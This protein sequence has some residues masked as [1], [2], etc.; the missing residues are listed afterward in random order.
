[1]AQYNYEDQIE[2]II[3]LDDPTG[4]LQE[5][6]DQIIDIG[7]SEEEVAQDDE[8]TILT[9]KKKKKKTPVTPAVTK[10]KVKE[11]IKKPAAIDFST[12][13]PPTNTEFNKPT[14]TGF[15]FGIEGQSAE[16][17]KKQANILAAKAKQDAL[18]QAEF[19]A[20]IARK[21][22]RKKNDE[23]L[24]KTTPTK[25]YMS[26]L[27][28]E[29]ATKIKE[30]GKE[31]YVTEGYG[32]GGE[33]GIPETRKIKINS[34]APEKSE[35]IDELKK[36]G[37]L[38]EYNQKQI[39][40][41]AAEKYKKKKIA[42]YVTSQS[43]GFYSD[44]DDKTKKIREDYL[45]K[46]KNFRKLELENKATINGDIKKNLDESAARFN[47]I[48]AELELYGTKPIFKNQEEVNK[49][50]KLVAKYN[51]LRIGTK[52]LYD[53]WEINNK[54]I[55]NSSQKLGTIEQE[56]DLTK[57]NYNWGAGFGT[58]VFQG[59][60]NL[61]AQIAQLAVITSGLSRSTTDSASRYIALSNRESNEMINSYLV[62]EEEITDAITFAKAGFNLVATQLPSWILMYATGGGSKA[63]QMLATELTEAAGKTALETAAKVTTEKVV[64][65]IAVEGFKIASQQNQYLKL[66]N[67]AK[68]KLT[69]P[70]EL[71]AMAL[72]SGAGKYNEQVASN[73]L[74][75]TNFTPLQMLSS[76]ALYGYAEALG[77][78]VTLDILKTG[79]RTLEAAVKNNSKFV[80]GIKEKTMK[81]WF[82]SAFNFVGGKA[83]DFANENI[84]EQFTN[85][86]QNAV[87]KLVLGKNVNLLDNTGTVFKDT[88]ILTSLMLTAPH[89]GGLAI[90]PFL[91][92][93]QTK[94]VEDTSAEM[95]KYIELLKNPALSQQERKVFSNK[96]KE[97]TEKAG[98]VFKNTIKDI[99]GMPK[100]VFRTILKSG[101]ELNSIKE[102]AK[103]IY[104]S[105]SPDKMQAIKVLE[106]EYKQKKYA[107]NSLINRT[108]MISQL[109]GEFSNEDKAK[110]FN[111]TNR[112]Q[113]L[114]QEIKDLKN[115]PNSSAVIAEKALE[116]KQIN[117]DIGNIVA[118]EKVSAFTKK[119]LAAAKSGDIGD[120]IFVFDTTAEAEAKAKELG[121]SLVDDEGNRAEGLEIDGTI[122][123][124][125]QQAAKMFAFNVAGHEVL[126][127]VLRKTIYSTEEIKDKE[128]N[129]IGQKQMGA[130]RGMTMALKTYLNELDPETL[131]DKDLKTRLA[132]YN[133][134]GKSV[135]AEETLTIFAD[136]LRLGELELNE[137]ALTKVGDFIR[138]ALQDLGW[139]NIKFKDGKDVL[140]FLK[141]YNRAIEKGKLG[142]AITKVAKEGATV[143]RGKDG[144]KN[145]KDDYIGDVKRSKTRSESLKEQLEELEDNE[146]DYDPDDFD[147]R[148]KSLKGQIARAIEKEKTEVKSEVKKEASEEDIVKEIINNEKGSISSDKVQ[149]IFEEKGVNGAA[150]II[151]LFKPITNKIVNKRKD[152]PGFDRELLTDEI[153]TG[154]GGILD[155][156]AK[157]KP[158]SGIPLAAW[159]N[160][161]L[162]VRA[163][164][165][166]RR[167]L[168]K[169]FNKDVTEEKGLLAEEASQEVK[170][171]PKYK[172]ALE[173][174]V[175]SPE[176]LE[177]ANKKILSV[178]RTLKSRIDA[179]VS[180]NKTVTPLISEIRDQ[181]GK[182]LDID[183]K[184]MLGGKKDGVLKKELLR[185]KQY[186]LEN[187]TTTWLM[188][189]DG[190]GGIPM[191][192]QKQIDGKWVNF[193]DWVG[194]K[195]D[196][197]KTTT[198]QA[199]R[200]SGAE[201]V[202]RLPNVNNNVS[203]EVF[204]S[205]IIGPDGNPLRGRKES[206]SKAIA[207]EA[208]FDIINNDFENE[209]PI[210]DAFKTNQERLGVELI[211]NVAT[212][213]SRQIERGN[214]KFSLTP[215]KFRQVASD[216]FHVASDYGIES[217]EVN[218][219]INKLPIDE[220][221]KVKEYVFGDYID[222]VA[223]LQNI[224]AGVRGTA[225]ENIILKE[226]KKLKLNGVKVINTKAKGFDSTGSGD[227]NIQLDSDIL[228]I[229]VKLNKLAQMGSFSMEFD[230]KNNTFNPSQK[231]D[232][233]E[234]LYKKLQDKL[235]SFEAYANAAENLGI[236]TSKW[237]YKITKE[238]HAILKK[239]GLQKNLTVSIDTNQKV[240]E[241][242]YNNKDVNY[243]NIG[244]NGLFSLGKD[245]LNL[246]VPQLNSKVKLTAR[247]V[248]GGD[249][250]RIRV[251]PTLIDFNQ[252]SKYNIDNAASNNALF[253]RYKE[254][255]AIKQNTITENAVVKSLDVK[256]SKSPKGISVFDFDD[257]VGLTKSNVLYT[258]PGDRM[259]YHGAPIGKDV[260][261]ISDK[262]VKFFATDKREADEYA[263][264]NSGTTQM[265]VINDSQI[266]DEEIAINK[267]KELGLT[268]KNKEFEI[269]DAQFYEL[270]DTRFEESLSKTDINKL[271]DAL[272]KDGVKA[273][274][275]SDGAQVSGNL[276]T[277]IAVIDTSVMSEP[278][279]L[280]AEEFAK[281]GKAMLDKGAVFD[282]SEFSKVTDG[283]PG[284]MVEKMKKMIGKFGP[285]NFFILT[286]R[287][288]D[289]AGPIHEFLQSIG[290]EIPLKNITGLG[291]SAAQAK[292]DWM[293]AKAAEG[294]ND[295]YFADDAIQNVEAVKKALNI[296]GVD[297]KVQQALAKFS[298]TS[299]R[300]L[301]WDI[302]DDGSL[303]YFNVNNKEYSIF[304][305][306]TG[307]FNYPDKERK[308]LNNL[309]KKYNLEEEE[310]NLLGSYEGGTLNLGFSDENGDIEITGAKN[311]FEVFGVVINGVLDYIKNN[312]TEGLVFT[313]KEPSRKKLYN[314]MAKTYADK[315]GWNAFYEDGV[316][317]VS[318]YPIREA[319]SSFDGQ[320]RPVKDVLNVVDIK[321]P[322]NQ[323]RGKFSK[324]ISSRFNEIIEENT[325]ME[326]YKVFSS[327]VARR[328]GINKNK[329][330]FYVPPSAADFELL[331]YKFMGKGSVG[332]E[333]QKFFADALLKPYANGNDLM[334]AARQS[335]KNDYKALLN[336]FPGIKNKIESLTPDGDFTYDQALR[337]AMWNEEGIEIPG[338][339]Q[340]DQTKLTDLINND[341]ELSAF[342]QGVLV[343]GRQGKG[344][345]APTEFWD[346]S[347]IISDL[348]NLTEGS[349]RKKF[350]AEFIENV[351]EMFGKFEN[352]KLVGPNMNKIEAVYGTNVREALD[353][354]L[355]RMINGKNRSYGND[356]ETS[357]W[358]N[359]VNGST[360]TIMF[361]NTRSAALQ[362]IGAVNFLNL[363]D[364]NPFAAA[365]AFANQ[366]QYWKDFSLIWNSDKMK[367]R[368]GGLKEDVAAAEIA[369]AAAG[370]K[371]KVN[372]VVSY[373][374]KIGYTPTQLAD[375]FAIA[376][377]GAPFYR[378][379]IK[380]YQAEY[381]G[382]DENGK[383][384]RKYTDEEAEKLAWNDFTKVS[385][386][387]QQSGDPRD[388][389]KQQASPAGRLLLTF[390]NTAMQQSRIVKK[391]FLD[392]KNGRGN[393]KT[394]LSKI[395]Y[396]LAIQNTL[397][398]VLQQGLFA[399]AF[400]D[401]DEELDKE[402]EKAKQKTT[403]EKLI[404]VA[405]GVLD[406]IL[407][408][409][410][411]LGGIISVLKNMTT[412]YLEEKD[413]D[414][415]ADYA[416]VMLEGANI[417]PPIGS[418]LR[419]IYT[420]LQQ[421]K[422]EKDLIE[423][424]G[425]S[426]M[427]DGRVH[428][429]PM[430]GV[431]G[432][433][434]EATT[435]LPMDRLVNKIENV[436]QAMNSQ[437]KT[438]QRVA[439]GLGFTPYSV[440]IEDTKGDLEIRA[441]A[442]EARKEAGT[443][444]RVD[445]AKTKRDSIANLSP[446]AYKAFVLKRK[447][448]RERKKDSIANLPPAQKEAYLKREAERTEA[449][450]KEKEALKK[451]KA[452]SI[453][454]LSPAER[455]N[456][457]KKVAAEKA[458]EKKERRE[459]YLEKKKALQDSLATLSPRERE[460]YKAKKKA[461]RHEYYI[462]NKKKKQ[463]KAA[464][465]Y[466]MQ[467]F[468]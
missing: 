125:K 119:T 152:A 68:N 256:R 377:G 57:R 118:T 434:V 88:S 150:E 252:K 231:I 355:Y 253:T 191:A 18:D 108:K 315:L 320:S 266:V 268:P 416:K 208:A 239:K 12:L 380:S 420:G 14:N 46:E 90:K 147:Q 122:I 74:G 379:R 213:I 223:K 59:F 110:L 247:L 54:D 222:F 215:E 165:T 53:T 93:D 63:E 286:A 300:D 411:F 311:A 271:F 227:V 463:K 214:V 415:K 349:G 116:L 105:E 106:D 318:K 182:Q 107:L 263:R 389:S 361:L 439:V 235:S 70:A 326:N 371:N 142:K 141:D 244:K 153:E 126:H 211:D 413:K 423:E 329:F 193:P 348:H 408:G 189:K 386:E 353:D 94:A 365:K 166:S 325:G 338:I 91:S 297:S 307:I 51:S 448:D 206:L 238:Q 322:I 280:N 254:N 301:K 6:E 336:Q 373:L 102:K 132:L 270:I 455:A 265:F 390:Q 255:L 174:K 156:I 313:A 87:D 154:V 217:T 207:E 294:Y 79:G 34:F 383:L 161:Y 299:K 317:I 38:Q 39:L 194:K 351:E 123:I 345:V 291:N 158:E 209:G 190:Q 111:L 376:S 43:I 212:E 341:P 140:N 204:L 334:D 187:M 366:P 169:E 402:K 467:V 143:V 312:G 47:D 33:P 71:R 66:L 324:S 52:D 292:A 104:N 426:V 400:D 114:T 451:I 146:S 388:I 305:R 229:E 295:F 264:M 62:P 392:L 35:V 67:L 21:A 41:L 369:N 279:K 396:Y 460:K 138:R 73:A 431:T 287:P 92:A 446:D 163:I 202:R 418:K 28:A 342:K 243:I 112:Q 15:N 26:S 399:V 219:I 461:E 196:R 13:K 139:I 308:I 164:A 128:G 205:Q 10:Q 403:N 405:N 23:F 19:E 157:Y 441:K 72:T 356:Q 302:Q 409:T 181:I 115:D 60:S 375:S 228:N 89:I 16:Y 331:L 100:N 290:I 277:S 40:E 120:N 432:K 401:D 2:E 131:K 186:I 327:I 9:K 449:R 159:I 284:P 135:K 314:A 457:N 69:L 384:K 357:R 246:G 82:G 31:T 428:L 203:D 269:D 184:T 452:D 419:K 5:D 436:S 160:K 316:Y 454:N 117:E 45:K 430:Y 427:Q 201:L 241:Q 412:K 360:G 359:W 306:D 289:S 368:R 167:I 352:G 197:E 372:A 339:S 354:Q 30:N 274:R 25:D 381:E 362:L 78:K 4:A 466:E 103:A 134:E 296:P 237:P 282:F 80:D 374:L 261:K 417:S 225:Y 218:N 283:K 424:R 257:T 177:S 230:A 364:N 7:V 303:T 149:S 170:E 3:E 195:I 337:V 175:F 42:S 226:L 113:N 321:S 121:Q 22:T 56:Y 276:T 278:K 17:K 173:S 404:D 358:S 333:Q 27:D 465:N 180:L 76:S 124:D 136:A 185:N 61:G 332:E 273:L 155:L 262:G 395:I 335:I 259:V 328:R 83:V 75:E 64:A 137:T 293:T 171:K 65:D 127:K 77:E 456:Y 109:K 85:I 310:A 216:L 99:D 407:R 275:Y 11:V 49:Y 250:N 248:R 304:L 148:I 462:K 8:L 249:Y 44:L 260:T 1:M 251:F 130:V 224:K 50:N 58:R 133:K 464:K 406:T 144:I 319:S 236:D 285:N 422:F 210:F 178:V 267:M 81:D 96:I 97:L 234:E 162:P 200:T 458:Q 95:K 398:A 232:G 391:S 378:N 20:R 450:K 443:V 468:D 425:W 221:E 442:K 382:L 298:L 346:A 272:R 101:N 36:A 233:L 145:Y 24:A 32:G 86:S 37:K 445:K 363:R 29:I 435:N 393:A 48:K 199:G 438:W 168:D 245:V 459:K 98:K 447:Q 394:H 453:A 281:E 444:K 55:A 129:V 421:T 433:L 350:L 242:L 323:K 258:M 183:V 440:G 192:I 344:W 387:T 367:E 343:T 84:S 414:F 437:N 198:D 288:A 240:I 429:G 340:R 179:P 151:K 347:T 397:F 385:D 330:D 176:V 188:G 220:R 309:I 410:G 370:S 172:N